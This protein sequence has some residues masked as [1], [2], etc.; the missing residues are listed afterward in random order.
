MGL[1]MF[2][3]AEIRKASAVNRRQ[4]LA[5]G[6]AGVG[7]LALPARLSAAAMP[8]D[9]TFAILRDGDEIGRHVVRFAPAD[10]GFRAR[11][12]IEIEVKVAFFTVFQFKQTADDLWFNGQ[13]HE[14]SAS[15]NDNGELS[16]TLIRATGNGLEVEGGEANRELEVPLGTMTD[17]AFWNDAIVRQQALVDTQKV[18]LTDLA[19][20]PRGT[21][22]VETPFGPVTAERFT[23]AAKAG[24]SGDIWFDADG[25]WVKGI[26]S[27]RGETLAYRLV[28]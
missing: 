9:R 7:C 26:M 4:I 23:V 18:R 12:E 11:T 1:R 17:L 2:G 28:A 22:T 27:V 21:E 15:T 5:G 10:N 13:L 8:A 25:N 3:E 14:S 19:A 24:R 20:Q 6:I 16:Q